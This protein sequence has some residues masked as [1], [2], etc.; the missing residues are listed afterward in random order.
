MAANYGTLTSEIL[1]LLKSYDVKLWD[2]YGVSTPCAFSF[3]PFFLEGH[4]FRSMLISR[5]CSFFKSCFLI[6][7]PNVLF[8][9]RSASVS[10]IHN[11]VINVNTVCNACINVNNDAL[12]AS[13]HVN[14]LCKLVFMRSNAFIN[15]LSLEE[16]NF[17]IT[18]VCQFAITIIGLL[19]YT[20]ACVYA[21]L[22]MCCFF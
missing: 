15:I 14:L 20:Y 11:F 18:N 1:L 21:R 3:L 22:H 19:E 12:I 10:A 9:A 6:D 4:S 7:N 2:V 17:M 13:P 8:I 5:F 16:T